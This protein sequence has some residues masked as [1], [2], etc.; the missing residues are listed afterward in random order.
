MPLD[1]PH[2]T[3]ASR[4]QTITPLSTQPNEVT[5][6]PTGRFRDPFGRVRSLRGSPHRARAR[7]AGSAPSGQDAERC[8]RARGGRSVRLRV[9]RR[10]RGRRSP[11][12]ARARRPVRRTRRVARRRRDARS[13]RGRW[14]RSWSSA[15]MVP[16]SSGRLTASNA[17]T[18]ALSSV[19]N[20][21]ATASAC[22]LSGEPL[23]AAPITRIAAARGAYPAG[24]TAT[25]HGAP[26]SAS[27]VSSPTTARLSRLC[28]HDPTTTRSAP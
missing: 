10:P 21:R 3:A 27:R 12:T 19:A 11:G 15:L 16:R 1:E 9:I 23:S 20:S 28:P 7:A 26:F 17:D 2:P 5:R 14:Q 13:A 4:T 8:V 18:C 6:L 24:A 22:T 25:A